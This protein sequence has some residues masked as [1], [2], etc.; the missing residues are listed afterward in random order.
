MGAGLIFC[1]DHCT[2]PDQP[3]FLLA[4]SYL[5]MSAEPLDKTKEAPN[6]KVFW[7]GKSTNGNCCIPTGKLIWGVL[8]HTAA[9]TITWACRFLT[10]PW[11]MTAKRLSLQE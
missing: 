5:N 11:P 9:G 6:G 2:N 8:R 1:L 4:K 7:R 10:T 3:A